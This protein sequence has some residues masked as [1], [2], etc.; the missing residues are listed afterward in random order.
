MTAEQKAENERT[1]VVEDL[2]E[3]L[4]VM[5]NLAKYMSEVINQISRA[6][7]VIY[8]D[9]KNSQAP[10]VDGKRSQTTD[11][12]RQHSSTLVSKSNKP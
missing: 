6:L 5:T 3:N 8:L 4:D 1:G 9:S 2:V 10:A 7:A 11:R 12:V